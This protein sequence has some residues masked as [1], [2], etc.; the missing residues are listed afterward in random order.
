MSVLE[1]WR[2]TTDESLQLARNGIIQA[3]INH[4]GSRHNGKTRQNYMHRNL[5]YWEIKDY[6]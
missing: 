6:T 2:N 3:V 4:R 1:G 5:G